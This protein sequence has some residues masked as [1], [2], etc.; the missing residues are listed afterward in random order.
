MVTTTTPGGTERNIEHPDSSDLRRQLVGL[1]A[2]R[3]DEQRPPAP[4]PTG[5]D[6]A[7]GAEDLQ[8]DA[9]RPPAV[10]RPSQ[11]GNRL[12]EVRAQMARSWN[13]GDGASDSSCAVSDTIEPFG[14]DGKD[15]DESKGGDG[16]HSDGKPGNDGDH[17]SDSDSQDDD[18]PQGGSALPSNSNPQGDSN[19]PGGSYARNGF[20][21]QGDFNSPDDL[22]LLNESIEPTQGPNEATASSSDPTGIAEPHTSGSAR[23]ASK[24]LARA[25][26]GRRTRLRR[27][28]RAKGIGMFRPQSDADDE[29]SN[30][31]EAGPSRRSEPGT[32]RREPSTEAPAVP[33]LPHPDEFELSD[34]EFPAETP[35]ES[36][37]KA[38]GLYQ[39]N[40]RQRVD[41]VDQGLAGH[42]DLHSAAGRPHPMAE[43][44]NLGARARAAEALDNA[45]AS[46]Q[47]RM[48][49]P[50]VSAGVEERTL[51][52]GAAPFEAAG[53]GGSSSSHAF[54]SQYEEIK[55]ATEELTEYDVYDEGEGEPWGEAQVPAPFIAPEAPWSPEWTPSPYMYEP[56]DPCP[57]VLF[58]GYPANW[59][60]PEDNSWND[61]WTEQG[62]GSLHRSNHVNIDEVL[63][64]SDLARDLRDTV[65]QA[66]RRALRHENDT[67][68]EHEGHGL[69]PD[70]PSPLSTQTRPVTDGSTETSDSWAR[71]PVVNPPGQ[72]STP[73]A[74]GSVRR[75]F[76]AGPVPSIVLTPSAAASTPSPL[77]SPAPTA[78][79]PR[80]MQ[81]LRR[82]RST[83]TEN[84]AP[85]TPQRRPA[86]DEAARDR[87]TRPATLSAA[88]EQAAGHDRTATSEG[89]G[90][91]AVKED[92]QVDKNGRSQGNAST[93]K[94]RFLSGERRRALTRRKNPDHA[95]HME[96]MR[97]KR[98]PD[99]AERKEVLRL[100]HM[101]LFLD[102]SLAGSSLSLPPPNTNVRDSLPFASSPG[103][104]Q[105]LEL[106]HEPQSTPEENRNVNQTDGNAP[107]TS[108]SNLN[109]SDSRTISSSSAAHTQ[110]LVLP[111][112]D[113]TVRPRAPSSEPP[114]AQRNGFVSSSDDSDGVMM[115]PSAQ[116]RAAEAA[117]GRTLEREDGFVGTG[118]YGE[119][120]ETPAPF[121]ERNYDLLLSTE[122]LDCL[123]ED[124]TAA[125]EIPENDT[126]PPWQ[127]ILRSDSEGEVRPLLD[128]QNSDAEII[129]DPPE[130]RN[131]RPNNVQ[132]N[133]P[134]NVPDFDVVATETE[135]AAARANVEDRAHGLLDA[136]HRDAATAVVADATAESETPPTTDEQG[137]EIKAP[138]QPSSLSS[139][140]EDSS[141]EPAASSVQDQAILYESDT[142]QVND[143]VPSTAGS[144]MATDWATMVKEDE[145]ADLGGATTE[146]PATVQQEQTTTSDG[147]PNS[148]LTP[149]PRIPFTS[150]P[151]SPSSRETPNLPTDQ[152]TST[153]TYA[154]ML[155]R[156]G[157]PRP[158]TPILVQLPP[159]A[160]VA[161]IPTGSRGSLQSTLAAILQDDGTSHTPTPSHVGG[162]QTEPEVASNE[163]VSEQ[164]QP[165]A[166]QAEA[167]EELPEADKNPVEPTE[168]GSVEPGDDILLLRV[169]VAELAVYIPEKR[170]AAS[171]LAPL[172][173]K[174]RKTCPTPKVRPTAARGQCSEHR[175]EVASAPLETTQG[176]SGPNEVCTGAHEGQADQDPSLTLDSPSDPDPPSDSDPSSGF[177]DSPSDSD[178]ASQVDSLTKD[179]PMTYD[180]KAVVEAIRDESHLHKMLP[181]RHI[182][183]LFSTY[184]EL[185]NGDSWSA[186]AEL[187]R[188]ADDA[189]T[190]ASGIMQRV[191][192]DFKRLD[193]PK[194]LIFRNEKRRSRYLQTEDL[195]H[196]A[197]DG[198]CSS[199]AGVQCTRPRSLK[200]RLHADSGP[201][202]K[203]GGGASQYDFRRRR[204]RVRDEEQPHSCSNNQSDTEAGPDDEQS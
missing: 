108:L 65:A 199:H 45:F 31:G 71:S 28:E 87:V 16:S 105:L 122:T 146:Q 72:R 141:T 104:V 170:P 138:A 150:E 64:N 161:R 11:L 167:S 97:L 84:E 189:W 59:T 67:G 12:E 124:E 44:A 172:F 120:T 171:E 136:Q 162:E 66:D 21:P 26:P 123:E 179:K 15:E 139:N 190:L 81:I 128:E 103:Q 49:L 79:S 148:Q 165:P 93:K 13:L 29:A 202:M 24:K 157:L 140:G 75:D 121:Q 17:S 53:N 19:L 9:S 82:P 176:C 95:E 183:A 126:R 197:V 191:V 37:H 86:N 39:E 69:W 35:A 169:E 32:L 195:T 77:S 115:A 42:N 118:E 50:V 88:P 10:P 143:S 25:K 100:K 78:P 130:V 55:H 8:Q 188:R 166:T 168:N 113:A 70:P 112:G 48:S 38:V 134:T 187:E 83:N 154:D 20:T 203:S 85:A 173:T 200:C 94:R 51:Q 56:G 110:Q 1:A 14:D 57:P 204:A 196:E 99:I 149:P 34:D 114:Q 175:A 116:R 193:S 198:A 58:D 23:T 180:P 46:A 160:G 101:H 129:V 201:W 6:S 192:A 194:P 18:K 90:K 119:A 159:A 4:P 54:A 125:I 5:T 109:D 127:S 145:M 73:N 117:R 182:R 142:A 36:M 107:A 186:K 89:K 30:D 174:A 41:P 80:P 63:A 102:P 7:V 164:S 163:P 156:R 137:N 52:P 152:P 184:Q 185:R 147:Q 177:S 178:S 76:A 22:N 158:T 181:R 60:Y 40:P 43:W 92:S 3:W 2:D 74:G 68:S 132:T 135:D 96:L 47:R 131:S 155:R 151:R 33:T 98:N 106:E 62:P 144:G 133:M 153:P 61:S 91:Q 111:P 27:R